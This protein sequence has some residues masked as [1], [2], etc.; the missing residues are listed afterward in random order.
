M[1]GHQG[2]K[3]NLGWLQVEKKEVSVK[4]IEECQKKIQ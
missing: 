4:P 3:Y 2:E 1:G